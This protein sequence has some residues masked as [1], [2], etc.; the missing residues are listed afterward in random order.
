MRAT[1]L[2]DIYHSHYK[3][4]GAVSMGAD[5]SPTSTI[6]SLVDLHCTVPV[7]ALDT[8]RNSRSELV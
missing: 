4:W 5:T 3:L 6:S 2:Y 1:A 8:Q 7:T